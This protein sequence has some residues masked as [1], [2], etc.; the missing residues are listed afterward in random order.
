MYNREKDSI[1]YCSI[2]GNEAELKIP[3]GVKII[4]KHAFY[5]CD[6]FERITLPASLLKMENNPFSGCSKLELICASSAY[7][8]KDDVIYNR[9]NTAVVGVL[10]K[11]KAECLIIPEGV[12]TINRNSFGIVKG[13]EQSYFRKL[14]KILDIIRL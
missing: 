5:L 10:N 2:I 7:N 8:V 11:I 9:Y 12:K 3:E 6:R 1:I 4:G 14:L 13:Y